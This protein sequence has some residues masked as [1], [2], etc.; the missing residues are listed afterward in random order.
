MSEGLHG[1]AMG[2]L[3]KEGPL[4]HEEQL[5]FNAW[6]AHPEN[7]YAYQRMQETWEALGTIPQGT[8]LP[9]APCPRRPRRR[10]LAAAAVLLAVVSLPLAYGLWKS[11]HVSY[12][13]QFQTAQGEQR[14]VTL[15]DGSV[16]W[17]DSRSALQVHYDGDRREVILTEG[18]GM[19]DVQTGGPFMVAAGEADVRVL[20]TAFSVRVT[21]REV[22]VAVERGRV[23][24]ADR[25]QRSVPVV[26]FPRMAAHLE[27]RGGNIATEAI[28]A[29]RIAPWR[30]GRIIFNGTPLSE[31]LAEFARYQEVQLVPA[32]ET[33][34][35]MPIS[36]TFETGE[37]ASFARAL[38]RALPV[39]IRT[40][41]AK[42]VIVRRP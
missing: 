40:Q 3:L 11:Q 42:E 12:L 23:E 13:K 4:S 26:L 37:V 17:L 31:A 14:K 32:S 18:Q 7:R 24:V 38:V 21:E 9:D 35:R 6:I 27:R 16:I 10:I 20:G 5:R 33:E 29:D 25:D 19:F 1:E 8:P 36:G 22:T 41:G 2:W 28:P 30:N 15:P 34:G 39:E